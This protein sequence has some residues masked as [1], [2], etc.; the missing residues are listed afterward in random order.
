MGRTGLWVVIIAALGCTTPKAAQTPDNP[1]AAA[2]ATTEPARV[3]PVAEPVK[4]V[5]PV[6]TEPVKTEPV[7]TEP[8]KTEPVKSEPPKATPVKTEPVKTTPPKAEPPKA[9]PPKPVAAA[10]EAVTAP[11]KKTERAWKAKCGSCHGADG[12]ATTEKGRKMKM[13]DLTTAAWQ[14]SRTNAQIKKSITDG[15]QAEKAGVKQEME[16]FSD[17]GAEQID[18][19]VKYVRWLGSPH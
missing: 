8:V 2:P 4:A 7:K 12:K 19:L 11:D 14:T 1:P 5:E 18:A 9:E 13:T 10:P 6:K 17:L 16:A 15:V 3:E